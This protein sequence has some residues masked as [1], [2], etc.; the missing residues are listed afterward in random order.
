[1]MDKRAI[2]A[3]LAM[4]AAT[5]FHDASQAQERRTFDAKIEKWVAQRIAP[6]LGQLRGGFAPDQS[7]AEATVHEAYSRP[8]P[9]PEAAKPV[10]APQAGPLP[11]DS[12]PALLPRRA[13][14]ALP[15]APQMRKVVTVGIVPEGVDPMITGSNEHPTGLA[16]FR[17]ASAEAIGQRV[18]TE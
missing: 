17:H 12:A 13:A 11:V 1:M 16:G 3:G 14:P 4:L 5:G 15:A 2:L 9:Q 6:R 10:S 18:V 8:A 7:L